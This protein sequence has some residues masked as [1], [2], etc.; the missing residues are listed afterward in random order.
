MSIEIR[1]TKPEEFRQFMET[2]DVPFG[3]LPSEQAI[4]SW[5][6]ILPGDRLF[7]A[8]D[9]GAM[10]GT[11]A[12]FSLEITVPGRTMRAAGVTAV[13][14]LPSHRRQGV[15]TRL[16]REQLED[17]RERHEPI[18]VLW[19]SEGA[20]YPH[21]GYGLATQTLELSIETT[22]AAFG[23]PVKPSGTFRLV[24]P[25]EAVPILSAIYESARLERPGM[26]ARSELWW[27]EAILWDPPARREGAGPITVAVYAPNDAP[28]GAPNGGPNG[29]PAAYAVYRHRPVW[30]SRGPKGELQVREVVAT[31][32]EATRD[33]W[34]WL[35]QHDLI[36]TVTAR[37]LPPDHALWFLL[38]EPRR[39]GFTAG[40]GIWSRILDVAPALEGRTYAAEGSLVFELSD[41]FCPWNAGRWRL[42]AGPDGARVARTDEPAAVALDAADLGSI[43]MGGIRATQLAAAGRV[44]EL[45][46][47]GLA[48]A[49]RLF[50]WPVAPWCAEV[51]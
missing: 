33:V 16:M 31:T 24:P 12:A 35:F 47:G 7:V 18:A 23:R 42:D 37:R 25:A 41:A 15:L 5:G 4:A 21:F 49:D 28:N 9:A 44:T 30:D 17:A 43:H 13:G 27:T 2:A 46:P 3:E 50:G 51:F 26:L 20:I 48:L 32:P 11:S 40:D 34:A 45:V 14:V 19:A 1:R 36:G 29:R 10:V 22:R 38:A 8:T 6:R 39:A